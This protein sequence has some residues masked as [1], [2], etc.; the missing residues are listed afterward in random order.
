MKWKKVF[1]NFSG[2]SNVAT[3]I[4]PTTKDFNISSLFPK[5]PKSAAPDRINKPSLSAA[6]DG[7]NKPTKP[8]A[9]PLEP[10]TKLSSSDMTPLNLQDDV[11]TNGAL[12]VS[13]RTNPS[14]LR[15]LGKACKKQPTKCATAGAGVGL[16]A[17]AANTFLENSAAQRD[18]IVQCLPTNWD[19]HKNEGI[20]PKLHENE[21]SEEIPRCTDGED[22]DAY[23]KERC[24]ALHP[25]SAGSVV[26]ETLKDVVGGTMDVVGPFA[27]DLLES[28]GF[29]MDT[30]LIAL[31]IL[32]VVLGAIAVLVAYSM[33][34]RLNNMLFPPRRP[35]AAKRQYPPSYDRA[36]KPSTRISRDASIS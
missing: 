1:S 5:N 4:Q 14:A 23:C 2:S 13:R 27:Y 18:C 11:V 35:L 29:P 32:P 19:R 10:S 25:T 9:S 22:C 21:E 6:P 16:A 20:F 26:G 17:Y 7:I 36:S 24:E 12:G 34:M 28:L 31:E 3:S 15:K 8:N 33:L 30:I